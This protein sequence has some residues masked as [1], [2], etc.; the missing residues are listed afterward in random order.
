[1]TFDDGLTHRQS[2]SHAII[3]CRI[4]ALE[5]FVGGLRCEPDSHIL[6]AQALPGRV[7]AIP[8]D[9]KEHR[10]VFYR[11]QDPMDSALETQRYLVT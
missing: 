10:M 6:Y 3:L 11:V 8:G 4:E 7:R 1:M 2:D 5:E 9:R